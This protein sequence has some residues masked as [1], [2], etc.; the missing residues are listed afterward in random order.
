MIR[1]I[2]IFIKIAGNHNKNTILF[3]I[4]NVY[5]LMDFFCVKSYKDQMLLKLCLNALAGLFLHKSK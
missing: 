3:T 2:F 5:L 4:G 1:R